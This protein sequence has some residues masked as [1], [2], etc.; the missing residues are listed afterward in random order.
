MDKST[1]NRLKHD[2]NNIYTQN[3]WINN[4][5]IVIFTKYSYDYLLLVY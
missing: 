3:I 2:I 1:K 4:R 5:F